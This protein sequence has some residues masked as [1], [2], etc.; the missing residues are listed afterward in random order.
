MRCDRSC[1]FCFA[2][3]KRNA[4]S[5]HDAITDM[6]LED[7]EKILLFLSRG[8]CNVIQIAGGEPTLHPKFKEILTLT[9]E[10]MRVNILSNC[11]WD[12]KLNEFFNGISPTYLGF[13]LN[14]DHPKVYKS[15]DWNRIQ[16]NLEF[17]S[18]RENVTLSFNIFEK[19]P[20]FQYIFDIIAKYQFKNLRLSFSM[21]VNYG[22]N[23]NT[24]LNIS[25]YKSASSSIMEFVKTAELFGANVGMDNALPICMFKS[26]DLLELILKKVI[27]P[28][29]NFVCYPAID[30]GPDLSVWRCFGTSKLFNQKL[31]D[32][33]SLDQM[34]EYYQ[35]VSRLYQFKF[36]PMKECY[37]CI[38]AK[39]EKCQGGCMGF[40]ETESEKLGVCPKETTDQEILQTKLKLSAGL[41]FQNYHYPQEST[42]VKLENGNTIEI[43]LAINNLLPL[44]DGN[45]TTR[46]ILS[47]T[48]PN[49]DEADKDG[50]NRLIVEIAIQQKIPV[51]RQLLDSR[52]LSK[53]A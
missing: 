3:E 19:K 43:P 50:L 30:I 45:Q 23:T 5:A 34:V 26:D 29:R 46:E 53:K 47:E 8:G 31:D 12:P 13:L 42:V 9:L 15:Q 48:M 24:R 2:K 49:F 11:M 21:P 27:L 32:F 37:D 20:E 33:N 52:V 28:E 10:R 35:R 40:A 17:L 4:Y 41:I 44:F 51:I 1:S 36:F 22:K 7:V 38:Y 18:K 14:V 25:E 16:E 39:T 6:S